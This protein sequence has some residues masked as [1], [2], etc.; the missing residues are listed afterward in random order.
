[1]TAPCL[2]PTLRYRD[3]DAALRWLIETV[4]F[5]EH[6]VHRDDQGAVAHAELSLGSSIL[7]LGQARDDEYGALV[8]SPDGRRTDSLYV[9]VDELDALLERVVA[10]GATIEMPLQDTPYGSREFVCRDAEGNLWSF[11]T[12]WPKVAD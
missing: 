1:M 12:Y 7:M 5:S 8:G 10:S 11:G 6:A 2:F 4:G 3:A 9:A